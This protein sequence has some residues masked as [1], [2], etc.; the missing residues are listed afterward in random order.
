M[1]DGTFICQAKY[2]KELLKRFEIDNAKAMA[3]Q[4][5]TSDHLDKDEKGKEV[6]VKK[7]RAA[8]IRAVAVRLRRED[9]VLYS[10]VKSTPIEVT[11]EQLG[12]I[13]GLP[14]QG[15][16][17]SNYG[18]ED[19]V[20]NNEGLVLNE[21]GITDLIPHA[22][23]RP[24]IHSTSPESRLLLYIVSRIIKPWKHGHTIMSSENLKLLQAIMHSTLI[25][26]AKFVMIYMTDAMSL[27]NDHLLPY[28]FLVMDILEHFKVTT[29]VGPLTKATK[30]W[31]IHDRTFKKRSENAAP[32]TAE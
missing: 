13:A 14:Y 22:T 23:G 19:W 10:L 15:N 11:V 31:T 7:Y 6:E 29:T 3:T 1:R 9:N 30:I 32:A 5:S 27:A 25:N 17:I 18:G 21:L 28:P 16:D 24:T 2:C 8:P 26:W 12:R 20:I 4:M